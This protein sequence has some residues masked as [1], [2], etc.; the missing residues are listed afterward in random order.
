M[1]GYGVGDLQGE[2]VQVADYHD[3]TG[4][5]IAQKIKTQDK[6]FQILGDGKKLPLW[7]MHRYSSGGR[8]LL[9]TE[10]ETDLLCWQS[11][12]GGKEWPGVSLPN[13]AAGAKASLTHHL[14][15]V[16][17]FDEVVL[18]FDGDTAGQAAAQACA[19]LLTPGK[20][21]IAVIPGG[22]NDICDAVQNGLAE[23]VIQAFWQAQP[24]RP[25]GIVDSATVLQAVLDH[26]DSPSVPYPWSGLN[27]KLL[28]IRAGELVT[29][30][31]GSGIGKS[32]I[33]RALAW[34]LI[35]SGHK[36]GYISL[37]ESLARTGYGFLEQVMGKPLHLDRSTTTDDEITSIWN[38]HLEGNI[39]VFNHYGSMDAENLLAK[40]RY[41]KVAE[42]C[43]TIF[44]DHLSILVS[45][46]DQS[47]GDERRLIDNV[48][49]ALRSTVEQT[50]CGMFL[51]CHLKKSDGNRTHEEGARPSLRDLRGSASIAQL[52][53]SVIGL[54]RDQQG[55]NPNVTELVVL[56]NRFSGVTGG[57]GYLR[58]DPNTGRMNEEE[59]EMEAT[60]HGF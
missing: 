23:Q 33:C 42:G 58:Y 56:K 18:F 7:Q 35:Q 47:Q 34:H 24:C 15:Y 38:E 49:T 2:S 41:M 11:I 51:V 43:S 30:T 52:S 54:V 1:H 39:S 21:R 55:D 32:Q 45:G 25:D 22:A 37:E 9:I 27:G 20:A 59:I 48:M 10:G 40:V 53:D 17:S 13:G 28:G 4:K 44:I 16:E 12:S 57:A 29:L 6:R 50:G 5:L 31:A 46:W 60:D 36:V 26:K 19:E 3:A 8:R 14:E